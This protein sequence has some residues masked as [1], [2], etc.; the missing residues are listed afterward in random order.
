MGRKSWL[1]LSLVACAMLMM[2]WALSPGGEGDLPT[3][4]RAPEPRDLGL[5]A[6]APPAPAVSPAVLGPSA[7]EPLGAE[8]LDR[9]IA[10]AK[11]SGDVNLRAEVLHLTSQCAVLLSG[12]T[13]PPEH[14]SER[15][16]DPVVA[17]QMHARWSVATFRMQQFCATGNHRAFDAESEDTKQA[18]RGSSL[19][20]RVA[21]AQAS[22]D[23]ARQIAVLDEASAAGPDGYEAMARWASGTGAYFRSH[24][25]DDLSFEERVEVG[26]Q[27]AA[28]LNGSSRLAISEEARCASSGA[29]LGLMAQV[30]GARAP[31]I[32]DAAAGI[33]AAIRAR[34]WADLGLQ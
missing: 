31:R 10:L 12:D 18:W 9:M 11:S 25:L 29:C 15:Y 33:A 20:G 6:P 7:S 8:R 1:A 21:A 17:S 34:R 3:P 5:V 4:P 14:F 28:A 19:R 30:D 2:V 22:G 32:R 16:G 23:R 24:G 27:V 13:L 26:R